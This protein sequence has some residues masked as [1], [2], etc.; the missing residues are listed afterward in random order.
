VRVRALADFLPGTFG[1]SVRRVCRALRFNFSI[2]FYRHRRP[3]QAPPKMRLC[4]LAAARIRYGYLRLHVL[5]RRGASPR[6][7]GSSPSSLLRGSTRASSPAVSSGAQ[8]S[9]G[10]LSRA[11]GGCY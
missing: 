10:P 11:R 3:D 7:C 2:Y 5:L 9:R 1:V 4:E 8:P 6:H